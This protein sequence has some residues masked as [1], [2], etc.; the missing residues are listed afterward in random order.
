MA[1][2]KTVGHG[3]LLCQ[4]GETEWSDSLVYDKSQRESLPSIHVGSRLRFQ[5]WMN[6]VSLSV[7]PPAEPM[8]RLIDPQKPTYELSAP[9]RA[10]ASK[11]YPYPRKHTLGYA[12][13]GSSP[14]VVLELERMDADSV[15]RL[16]GKGVT[17]KGTLMGTIYDVFWYAPLASWVQAEVITIGLGANE[18][19]VLEVA[20]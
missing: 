7:T 19:K 18:S 8:L 9:V 15:E 12:L 11:E 20:I 5:F 14:P 3:T 17:A 16:G 6:P 1:S 2:S 4:I 10:V 13:L